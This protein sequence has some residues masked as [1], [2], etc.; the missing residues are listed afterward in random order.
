MS[1]KNEALK[2]CSDAIRLCENN[3]YCLKARYST[4]AYVKDRAYDM[5]MIISLYTLTGNV[6]TAGG[7]CH[8]MCV[9]RIEAGVSWEHI[10]AHCAL[11]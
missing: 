11:D 8:V 1:V 2:R 7:R 5:S 4:S 3:T 10:K 6:L 9:L